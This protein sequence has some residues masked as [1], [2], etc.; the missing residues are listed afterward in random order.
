MFFV[1]NKKW[2]HL[3]EK[4]VNNKNVSKQNTYKPIFLQFEDV[5]NDFSIIIIFN[6]F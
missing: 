6:A 3:T 2:R 5:L 4:C 1:A